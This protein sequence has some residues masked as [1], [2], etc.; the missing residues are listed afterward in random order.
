M[1][2]IEEGG[3]GGRQHG[4]NRRRSFALINA[5]AMSYKSAE[6]MLSSNARERI[7]ILK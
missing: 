1:N 5:G 2:R 4:Y 6:G 3:G 7:E